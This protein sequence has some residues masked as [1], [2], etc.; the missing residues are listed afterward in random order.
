MDEAEALQDPSRKTEIKNILYSGYKRYGYVFRAGKTPN[1]KIIP[2]RFEV[3]SPKAFVTYEG[4]E[5]ILSDRSITIVMLRSINKEITKAEIVETD[6]VWGKLRNKFYVF[7][8]LNWREIRKIYNELPEVEEI[9]SRERE[10]WRPILALAKFFGDNL[11][12]EM[13]SLAIKKIKEKEMEEEIDTRESILL[14]TLKK[15]VTCDG[16]YAIVDIRDAVKELF[17]EELTVDWIGKALSK[18]F[19]FTEAYRLSRKG[20][21]RAR[22]L[23][24]EKVEELCKRY[25]VKD[26]E[27]V[28][29]VKED[30]HDVQ[31]VQDNMQKDKFTDEGLFLYARDLWNKVFSEDRIIKALI[32]NCDVSE[33][34]AKE[35]VERVRKYY[36]D[37]SEESFE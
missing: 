8:L 32:D 7:T 9:S 20:R 26:T 27:A 3:F 30:V 2:E 19:G 10:L 37:I 14:A 23:T 11:Y 21:P 33:E 13:K 6:P 1:E 5:E 15:I 24:V 28:N 36:S 4:L 12:E 16:I 29:T 31:V 25:N 34:K 17:D 35:I 18:K 22:R